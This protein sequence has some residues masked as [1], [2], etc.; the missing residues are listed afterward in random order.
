MDETMEAYNNLWGTVHGNQAA[1]TRMAMGLTDILT[2]SGHSPPILPAAL[3][4]AVKHPRSDTASGSHSIPVIS[5]SRFS[6]NISSN[7]YSKGTQRGT[8]RGF[9]RGSKRGGAAAATAGG[10][11]SAAIR[12]PA[13]F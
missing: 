2:A 3:P 8:G 4:V 11:A 5:N 1:Y 10:E 12:H 9:F 13:T 7:P 6:N